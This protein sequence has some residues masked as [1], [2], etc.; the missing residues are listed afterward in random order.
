VSDIWRPSDK[1]LDPIVIQRS[2]V[3][4]PSGGDYERGAHTRLVFMNLDRWMPPVFGSLTELGSCDPG[5]VSARVV[6]AE[7]IGSFPSRIP[8]LRAG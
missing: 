4:V 3:R 6:D 5:E 1:F 8:T 7:G 2:V